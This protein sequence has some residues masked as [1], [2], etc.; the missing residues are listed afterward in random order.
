[1]SLKRECEQ[2]ARDLFGE[3]SSVKAERTIGLRWCVRVLGPA[4]RVE[5]FVVA[6]TL[7][8]AYEGAR[9]WLVA[10]DARREVTP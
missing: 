9:T 8:K 2:L 5:L 3:N 1:M 10:A 7:R 6:D 4:R